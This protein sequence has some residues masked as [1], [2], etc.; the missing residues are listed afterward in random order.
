MYVH[1]IT[2]AIY[3]FHMYTENVELLKGYNDFL[4]QNIT[5][6]SSVN[7]TDII[8]CMLKINEEF[9]CCVTCNS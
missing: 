3:S 7:I 8:V 5:T 1:V 4:E 2:K 6:N 9:H